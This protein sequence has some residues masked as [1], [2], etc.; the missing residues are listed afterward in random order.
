MHMHANMD[1]V[2]CSCMPHRG[3]S[4]FPTAALQSPHFPPL[5]ACSRG[6]FD[7]LD[8]SFG[9]EGGSSAPSSSYPAG[10]GSAQGKGSDSSGSSGSKSSGSGNSHGGEGVACCSACDSILGKRGALP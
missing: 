4:H 8:G 7:D 5:A 2:H 1:G 3:H 6:F 9:F 10:N